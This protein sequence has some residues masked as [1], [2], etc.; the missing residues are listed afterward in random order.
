MI[1]FFELWFLFPQIRK[2]V[3]ASDGFLCKESRK[4]W[5]AD[6]VITTFFGKDAHN[7]YVGGNKMTKKDV[8]EALRKTGMGQIKRFFAF[9]V[10]VKGCHWKYTF[11][12]V[13]NNKRQK[14]YFLA[15]IEDPIY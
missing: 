7:G 14:R 10:G 9:Y 8:F 5:Q 11:I 4:V 6:E 15:R 3:T 12:K 1:I 13:S 2:R